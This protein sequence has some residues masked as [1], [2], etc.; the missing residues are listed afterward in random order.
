MSNPLEEHWTAVKQILHY[1][2]AT[3]HYGL[4]FRQSIDITLKSFSDVD[5]VSDID[6]GVYVM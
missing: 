3:S 2:A 1:L 4:I 5:W 6:D